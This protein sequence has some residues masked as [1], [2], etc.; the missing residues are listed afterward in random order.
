MTFSLINSARAIA[1]I[2]VLG[3]SQ[4]MALGPSPNLVYI[5]NFAYAGSGCP[6]G[7]AAINMAVDLGAIT[8]ITDSMT[9]ESG[10]SVPM[11]DSRKLCQLLVDIHI[12]TGWQYSISGVETKGYVQ[13]DR[14]TSA[15][16]SNRYYFSGNA[17]S[18][19]LQSTINGPVDR[20]YTLLDNIAAGSQEIWSPCGISRA[21]NIA[22]QARVTGA[23]GR[24][25]LLSVDSVGA[26]R[27][28]LV[29][30]RRCR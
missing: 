28:F 1:F 19:T 30:W 18:A 8:V 12:P 15:F 21:L 6:A 17:A 22:V 29:Q 27:R 26:S 2:S 4:A 14:G 7:S 25:A 20:D 13:L 5:N 10:P 9:A 11:T 3:A 23:S 16:Q 24:R